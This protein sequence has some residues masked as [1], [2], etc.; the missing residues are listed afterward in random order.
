MI[1]GGVWTSSTPEE[2]VAH[3]RIGFARYSEPDQVQ[4][5]VAYA[6]ADTSDRV[7]VEFTAFRLTRTATTTLAHGPSS[8]CTHPYVLDLPIVPAAITATSYARY[9]TSPCV[10]YSPI[11]GALH[12]ADE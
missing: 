2:L 6:V 12:C 8:S 7:T 5:E 9:I 1:G 3:V 4:K 10:Y 11:A